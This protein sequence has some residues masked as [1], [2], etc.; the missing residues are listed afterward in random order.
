MPANRPQSPPPPSPSWPAATP[1]HLGWKAAL[2][3]VGMAIMV[4]ACGYFWVSA[5]RL[6]A[7]A[8]ADPA[9]ELNG[10][11]VS[12][13]ISV[14]FNQP[15]SGTMDVVLDARSP[16]QLAQATRTLKQKGEGFDEPSG[17]SC[18]E[19]ACAPNVSITATLT[20]PS[21]GTAPLQWLIAS[22]GSLR[23]YPQIQ[24]QACATDTG[25][26]PE[27]TIASGPGFTITGGAELSCFNENIYQEALN[28]DPSCPTS[29][30]GCSLQQAISDPNTIDG[31]IAYY[32]GASYSDPGTQ[33]T[34]TM[35][36]DV[37]GPVDEVAS[38]RMIGVTGQIG[39]YQVDDWIENQST[40]SPVGFTVSGDS[41]TCTGYA[42]P[43]P[44]SSPAPS[45][46]DTEEI[47]QTIT[48]DLGGAT[49]DAQGFVENSDK[50]SFSTIH[51]QILTDWTNANNDSTFDAGTSL[52]SANIPN[53]D[54]NALAW[55]WNQDEPSQTITWEL[56]NTRDR[57]QAQQK[58]FFAGVWAS[59]AVTS[60]VASLGIGGRLLF[61]VGPPWTWRRPRRRG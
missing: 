4:G 54:A 22:S 28:W 1:R 13:N 26:V 11:L 6:H 48:Q 2:S 39:G 34:F 12:G 52:I 10:A 43:E 42:N 60:A 3:V 61:E 37:K 20:L 36:G 38:G 47:E 33:V 53:E 35:V 40:C 27:S 18:G 9:D 19:L 49:L 25:S 16:A 56:E 14:I 50:A 17:L 58:D 29:G 31:P 15:V 45:H 55:T 59:A 7:A 8:I 41:S 21:P 51:E 5:V 24:A 30:G 46:L 23:L 44:T 57:E 32:V